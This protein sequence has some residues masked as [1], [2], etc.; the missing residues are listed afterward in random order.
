LEAVYNEHRAEAEKWV[1]ANSQKSVPPRAASEANFKKAQTKPSYTKPSQHY[2]KYRDQPIKVNTDYKKDTSIRT[3]NPVKQAVQ[4]V[5][6]AKP[7][8]TIVKPVIPHSMGT[9]VGSA[10][11]SPNIVQAQGSAPRKSFLKRIL[12]RILGK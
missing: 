3:P 12:H 10:K 11:G 7:I 4:S 8:H 1:Q 9:D 6:Q 5:E 2:E